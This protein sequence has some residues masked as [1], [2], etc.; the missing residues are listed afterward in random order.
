MT[1]VEA[2]RSLWIRILVLLGIVAGPPLAAEPIEL[3]P[4]DN[5]RMYSVERAD[6]YSSVIAVL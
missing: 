5:G 3:Y 2:H 6:L 1:N 4:I